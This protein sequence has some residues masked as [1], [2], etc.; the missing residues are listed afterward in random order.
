MHQ[1][2]DV[3]VVATGAIPIIP[4]IKGLERIEYTTG[5]DILSGK[6]SAGNKVLIIGGGMIGM[7]TAEFLAQQ[8]K[9][10][11]VIEMM[12]I[13]ARDMEKITRN[14]LLKRIQDL[15]IRVMENTVVK[16]FEKA[17][18]ILEKNGKEEHLPKFDTV[19]LTVGTRPV[20]GLSK[21]IKERGMEVYTIGDVLK[22]RKILDAIHEGF[23]V[24]VRI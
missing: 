8:S 12:D 19:I 9:E 1:H 21:E 16:S 11:T 7:E 4:N 18:V 6:K 13:I 24:G 2:P 3:V 23:E 14:L 15:P 17:E 22:P 10:I 5:H 20:N